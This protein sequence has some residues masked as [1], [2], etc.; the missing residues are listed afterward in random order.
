MPAPAPKRNLKDEPTKAEGSGVKKR[1]IG[2]VT[3]EQQLAKRSQQAAPS[4]FEDE[5]GKLTQDLVELKS[6][7]P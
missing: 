2:A 1:K 4:S 3:T 6:G 7:P 5:L